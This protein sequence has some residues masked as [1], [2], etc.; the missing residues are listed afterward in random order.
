MEWWT[1]GST[2]ILP[3]T[4]SDVKMICLTLR[5]SKDTL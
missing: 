1:A 4:P 2:R 3:F 5:P